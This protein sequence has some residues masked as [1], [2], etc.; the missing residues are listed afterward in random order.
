MVGAAFGLG[1]IFGPALGGVLTGF[2]L[3]FLSDVI[4]AL[5]LSAS[6]PIPLAAWTPT[7]VCLLLG[8]SIL[9]HAEDG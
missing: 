3:H 5:G 7:G 9:L 6:I 8:A 4:F 1:F 2:L